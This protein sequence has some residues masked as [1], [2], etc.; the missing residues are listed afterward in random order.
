MTKAHKRPVS[1]RPLAGG[2]V[3]ARIY[4]GLK[5]NNLK[6]ADLARLCEVTYSAADRWVKDKAFPQRNLPRIA[7]VLGVK[8]EE[9]LGI[10][11]GQEPPYPAWSDFLGTPVAKLMSPMQL[12]ALRSVLWPPGEEPTV[13]TYNWMAQGLMVTR[14]TE[15]P[16]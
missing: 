13:E 12:R 7:E 14:R 9:L 2:T 6:V 1:D 10:H 11:E 5:R 4:D 15:P 16:A 8:I 3:G